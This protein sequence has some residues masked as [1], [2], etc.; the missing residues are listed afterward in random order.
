[1]ID[2]GAFRGSEAT[3]IPGPEKLMAAN[4]KD[5]AEPSDD[6]APASSEAPVSS[7]APLSSHEPPVS[8][9][10]PPP[11]SGEPP[12][13]SRDPRPPLERTMAAMHQLFPKLATPLP[14]S[15]PAAEPA[16]DS[17]TFLGDDEEEGFG[18]PLLGVGGL[19]PQ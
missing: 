3:Q 14:P 8:S 7:K 4:P 6:A 16:D 17:V 15:P 1:M 12:P 5:R 9:R 19:G 2:N 11:S 10:E 13:S 18:Q